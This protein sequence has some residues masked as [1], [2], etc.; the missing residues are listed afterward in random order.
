[1]G[2]NPGGRG[3]YRTGMHSSR[4]SPA[5]SFFTVMTGAVVLAGAAAICLPLLV[6]RIDLGARQA[7][8]AAARAAARVDGGFGAL[9]A[10]V[11]DYAREVFQ[12]LPAGQPGPAPA[13]SPPLEALAIPADGPFPLARF[14]RLDDRPRLIPPYPLGRPPAWHWRPRAAERRFGPR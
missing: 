4:L 8:Q 5:F 6:R 12:A 7:H 13:G 3:C 14:W 11:G 1:M 9:Q 2:G 10:M